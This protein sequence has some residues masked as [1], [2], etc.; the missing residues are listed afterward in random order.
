MLALAQPLHFKVV[1]ARAHCHDC[2]CVNAL[3]A[4][5]ASLV[6]AEEGHPQVFQLQEPGHVLLEAAFLRC[7]LTLAVNNP[8]YGFQMSPCQRSRC[9]NTLSVPSFPLCIFRLSPNTEGRANLHKHTQILMSAMSRTPL[10]SL[11]GDTKTRRVFPV[12][13]C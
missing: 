3:N 12:P 13:Q 1:E 7:Y 8:S 2:Y 11:V 9:G 10:T 4:L 6:R 5:L